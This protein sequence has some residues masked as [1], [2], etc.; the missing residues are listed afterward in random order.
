[1]MRSLSKLQI[2]GRRCFVMRTDI[3]GKCPN[4]GGVG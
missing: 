3:K 4:R 2:I 1:M